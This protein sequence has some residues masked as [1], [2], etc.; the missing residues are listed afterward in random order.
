ME[1][2][3][4]FNLNSVQFFKA[5]LKSNRMKLEVFRNHTNNP[6]IMKQYLNLKNMIHSIHLKYSARIKSSDWLRW[7]VF[8]LQQETALQSP[9]AYMW[10][11]TVAAPLVLSPHREKALV[12]IMDQFF[13]SG[14]CMLFLRICGL[15][16]GTPASVHS[17]KI[18]FPTVSGHSKAQFS[19]QSGDSKL[20]CWCVCIQLTVARTGY[21]N[22]ET[23][24]EG[25]MC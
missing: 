13:L 6:Q 8:G 1:N 7:L 19:D 5:R 21:C 17:P 2:W 12:Q 9:A 18:R 23:H 16:P 20:L 11:C 4:N 25:G 10:S 24:S 22:P 14:V 15:S 3:N